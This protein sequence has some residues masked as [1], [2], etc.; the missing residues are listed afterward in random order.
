M[1]TIH[2]VG[3]LVIRDDTF[4]MVRKADHETWTTLGGRPEGNETEEETLLREIKEEVDCDATIL[5]KVGDFE[6]K[7]ADDDATIHLSVYLTELKGNIHIVDPELA[8]YTYVGNDYEKEGIKL[9]TVFKDHV[10]PF[11]LKEGLLHWQ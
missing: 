4:L 2:K 7:A 9:T 5:R 6:A 8:E 3:A 10:L 11:C 1:R